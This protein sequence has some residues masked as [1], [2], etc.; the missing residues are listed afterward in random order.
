MGRAAVVCAALGVWWWATVRLAWAGVGCAD[1]GCLLPAVGLLVLLS[2][3]AVAGS[4][5]ALERVGVRP[6][7]RVA[8]TAA[9]TLVV[10]RLA[11]ESLPSS[12]STLAD[13][14]AY[15][16]ACAFAGVLAAFMTEP[17]VARGWR[18]AALAAILALLPAALAL[19]I[20]RF[21]L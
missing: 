8:L 1:W 21:G 13:A 9:G 19:S 12:T 5:F 18:V 17:S 10:L 3:G 15:G 6:G 2:A 14:A 16:V 4:A 20:A 7:R 11:A